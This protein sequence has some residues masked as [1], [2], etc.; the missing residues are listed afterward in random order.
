[1]RQLESMPSTM[2]T[3]NL[4]NVFSKNLLLEDILKRTKTQQKSKLAQSQRNIQNIL[5]LKGIKFYLSQSTI[6]WC[7]AVTCT[8][9]TTNKKDGKERKYT[10]IVLSLLLSIT[11]SF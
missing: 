4:K 10:Q 11:F 8:W 5:Q 3:Q 2:I 7:C 9:T 1:M 6:F